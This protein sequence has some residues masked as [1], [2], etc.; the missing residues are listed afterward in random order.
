M[1]MKMSAT[2]WLGR[3]K[4]NPRA[5]L[6]L[7][8]FPYAGGGTLAYRGWAE[9]LPDWVEVCPVQLP[10]REHRTREPAL[11]RIPDIVEAAAESLLPYLDKPFAL[12]GHSMGALVSFDLA[13]LL[14]GRYENAPAGLFVSG[15]PAPHVKRRRP[16]TYDLPE[17]EFVNK[18]RALN[19]TPRELLDDPDLMCVLLPLLR[20][21]FE[22]SETYSYVAGPPL[23]CPVAA[24]GG[25][26]DPEAERRDIREWCE[27][28]TAAFSL[29]M[30]PGDHF[31]L[32]SA[33][34]LLLAAI[35]QQ[36]QLLVARD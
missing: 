8:C 32:H 4:P 25:T 19:G 22:A 23:D 18:L 16:P 34:P 35:A 2:A 31:F 24:F 10:G 9:Q 12:F 30:F 1:S 29:K 15:C 14:R 36:L 21:D 33:R 7:F 13:R 17:L 26:A 27:H 20:A 28:T 3:F 5:R 11:R 6:R